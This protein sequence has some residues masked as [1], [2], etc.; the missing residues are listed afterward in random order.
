MKQLLFLLLLAICTCFAKPLISVP[1][2]SVAPSPNL[3]PLLRD[4]FE[5][6]MQQKMRPVPKL[7]RVATMNDLNLKRFQVSSPK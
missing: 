5:Q 2:A 6:D 7:S 1:P 3:Y 4:M